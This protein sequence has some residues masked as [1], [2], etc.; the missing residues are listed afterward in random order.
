MSL[1]LNFIVSRNSK[2]SSVFPLFIKKPG[3]QKYYVWEIRGK[4]FQGED[5]KKKPKEQP[6]AK[7][8]QSLNER[9]S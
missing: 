8:I 1:V 2:Q 5:I 6:T 7:E 9:H 4:F 3:G